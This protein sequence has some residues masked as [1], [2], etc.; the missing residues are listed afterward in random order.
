MRKFLGGA[1]TILVGVKDAL[2]LLFLL[3]FF[4]LLYA[5]LSFQPNPAG[6]VG[7]GVLL[8]DLDGVVVEQAA[9]QDLLTQ[10][11]GTGTQFAEYQQRDIIRALRAAKSDTRVKAVALD[12]DLFAGGGQASLSAIAAAL[13][14]VRAAKKPV[15]AFATFYGDDAYQ[16]AA[17][18]SEVW[19]DPLGGAAFAGPGGSRLYYKS[20]IDQLGVTA[21]IYRAG[22]YKSAVEPYLRDDQSPEAR[23]AISAV[24]A[25]LWESW[26]ADVTK[27]RPAARV[28]DYARDPATLA[29]QARGDL[30]QMALAAKLVDRIGDRTAFAAMLA[31]KYGESEEITPD[32]FK[33]IALSDYIAANPVA[34]DG[35]AIDVVTV[36][37]ELVSGPFT[38]G[39]AASGAVAEQIYQ[40]L[41]DGEMKALVVR[42]D[43]PGGSV[44]ASE[45]IRLALKAVRDA[46]IP[47]VISMGDVAASGG[48]WLATASDAIFAE[49]E[50]I[51]GSI[52]VFAV[53]PSFE[54]ALARWGVNADGVQTTPLSGEPDL[55]GGFGEQ[56]GR[57]AQSG[58]EHT[59]AQFITLV[60]KAR[61]KSPTQIDA[62]G[63]GRVWDGGTAH[64]L[65]LV[66]RLGG[67]DAAL[68]EAAKRAKLSSGDYYPRYRTPELAV[69]DWLFGGGAPGFI[70]SAPVSHERGLFAFAAAQ[71]Q[72]AL[73]DALH[74]VQ[75]L[76]S[77]RDVQALCLECS[78]ERRPSAQRSGDWAGLAARLFAGQ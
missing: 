60:A 57:I 5:A 1:W 17:Q 58:V 39:V 71:Q 15:Y 62:I 49:P 38:P 52:G 27:A 73:T 70:R 13:A 25:Q 16:L 29:E 78:G 42:V 68:A 3:L 67:L 41:K 65:G 48:Y 43:S 34:S 50:T 19:L 31:K 7:E 26:Q 59:Y 56:F 35:S 14:E 23:E 53:L 44:L 75:L 4:A 10:L 47:V 45:E 8:L 76:L 24:Y 20:L 51:T 64:Q 18:A 69:D 37:G 33:Q 2:V 28:A 40:A 77:G 6:A 11:S 36:S 21:H 54:K 46:K 22:T 12:L 32:N 61:A 9:P 72:H 74:S 66:D 55:A 63:Q 30:A